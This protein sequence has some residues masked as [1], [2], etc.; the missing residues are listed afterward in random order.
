MVDGLKLKTTVEEVE[1]LGTVNV[2]GCTEQSLG[3]ALV[4]AEVS[5]THGEMT[6]GDLYV[7]RSC[8]HVAHE[9]VH[10]SC[11]DPRHTTVHDAVTEPSPKEC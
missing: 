5:G 1:P 9:E 10:Y 2:H 7:E 11:P 8:H 3:E 4:D 6:E